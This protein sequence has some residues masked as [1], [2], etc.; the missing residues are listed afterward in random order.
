MGNNE[1][2]QA[3]PIEVFARYP[4]P[5][6]IATPEDCLALLVRKRN[7]Y[8]FIERIEKGE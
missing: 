4:D 1:V 8:C 5:I 6:Q 7:F 2:R 3:H